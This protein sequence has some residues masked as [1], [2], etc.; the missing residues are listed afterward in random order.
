MLCMCAHEIS[1]SAMHQH[2]AG[3]TLTHVQTTAKVAV[4]SS[5]PVALAYREAP[6][7]QRVEGIGVP[8]CT[9]PP[10]V[11]FHANSKGE[12]SCDDGLGTESRC[13]SHPLPHEAS[14]EASVCN[15]RVPTG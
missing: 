2:I 6:V 14:D 10:S 5:K 13:S 11:T 15:G 12:G 1:H 7:A 8:A 3:R 4:G 9:G